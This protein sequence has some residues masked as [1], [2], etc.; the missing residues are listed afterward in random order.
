MV[1]LR[2]RLAPSPTGG[3]HVGNVRTLMLA[4]LSARAAGGEVVLRV[5]DLDR[6]RCK[7]GYTE[8]MTADL[9]WLGFDWDEGP[10]VG[11]PHA[12]YLQSL[13]DDG[14]ATAL[15]RLIGGGW[16]YPCVCSRAELALAAS[17][18]HGPAGPAYPGTCR[19]RFRDAEQARR[20]SGREP[21]W[22]FDSRRS[23][24]RP[25]Q[26]A[27]RPDAA[28]PMDVDDF[29]LWRADGVPAY[30]LAVVV[31]DL[32]MGI[33]E[34]VRGD[35]L[36]DSTPRQLALIAALGGA[37]PAYR[38]VSLVQD[39]QG[40]RLA[41]RGGATQVA[42]LREIGAQPEQIIGLLAHSAGVAD[43][44][45]PVALTSLVHRFTWDRVAREPARISEQSLRALAGGIAVLPTDR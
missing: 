18:P 35:D 19:D 36:A 14:Y 10:D 27:F 7:P 4:W 16:A 13:R 1:P 2:A 3:L 5:E 41:K 28:Q 44:P 20:E 11:G 26:D 15:Q 9:R 34:V 37:A 43:A 12:P 39:E 42:E 21:A 31:D 24:R 6:A 22:R 29:V 25:W 8:Q 33:T 32:A 38:H 45:S 17:A 30:Q 40:N 23:P